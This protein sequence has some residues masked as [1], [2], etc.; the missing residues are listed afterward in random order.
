MRSYRSAYPG[1]PGVG[2][3][4]YV[5]AFPVGCATR[6]VS[7]A[8]PGMSLSH[9]PW[10]AVADPGCSFARPRGVQSSALPM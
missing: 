7:N 1:V 9:I 6:Y 3:T 8:P 2:S 10:N 5:V 4:S